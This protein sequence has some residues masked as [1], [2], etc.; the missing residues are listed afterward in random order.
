MIM[1]SLHIGPRELVKTVVLENERKEEELQTSLEQLDK[2]FSVLMIA[3][4]SALD[5]KLQHQQLVLVDFIRWIEHRMDWVGE[6]SNVIDLN[7][8]LK[9]LHPYFDFLDCGLIVDMSE[10]FL[11]DECFGDKDLVSQL[12][13]HKVKCKSLRSSSTVKQL[14]D[15]LKKI[16]FPHHTNP[17]NM[18][19]I[20]IALNNTWDEVNIKQ[21]YLLIGH[22]LPHKS[23][24][25]ILKH[26]EIHAGSVII[27]FAVHESN[28]ECLIAYAQ[29]KLQFMRL[30]GIF[31]LTINGK[32]ILKEDEN[33]NF[34]FKLALLQ[35]ANVGHDEAVQFLLKLGGNVNVK[36]NKGQTT[37]MIA[38]QKGHI[39]VIECLLKE[40]ADVNIQTNDGWTALMIASHYA[41]TQV[42][43]QL[44]R[45]HPDVN[46][47]NK[48]GTTS[49]ML[50][51]QNGHTQV[52][53][54]LLKEQAAVNLQNKEGTTSLMLASQNGH[55]QVVEQLLKEHA[56]V[57]LQSKEGVTALMLASKYGY[58]QVIEQLLKAHADVNLRNKEGVTALM[59][60]SKYGH[61]QVVE[62]LL[63][64]HANVNL[65]TNEGWT[66]LMTA[67]INGHTEVVE[68]LL[69]KHADIN[70]Q[71]N[72]GWT[73]LMAASINDHTTV[74]EVLLKEHADLNI[75]NNEGW[76]ALMLA[77]QN[78]HT[79][80]V[81]QLLKEHA[82]V[83]LQS[84]E[85][86][87]ALMLASKY[88]YTQVIEQLLKAHADVNL[89]NKE[90]VT[91]LMLASKYGHTQVVEQLLKEHA[92]VN[93]QTNE[94]W[95]ALMTASI[96]GHTEVVEQLLKKHAD[97]NIQ[98]NGGWTSLM[99][100]SINDH[101]T[102][103]E[104][105]LKEHAD[106]NIQ[107]NEGWTALMLA[108]RNDHTK[109]VEQLLKE[110]ADVN[111]QNKKGV[112]ALMLA[113]ENGHTQV[114]EAILKELVDID[115]KIRGGGYTALML[116]SIKG[117]VEVADCLLQSF[118]DPHI[119]A[120]NGLMAFSL[121][122]FNGNR[123]LVHMF[124]DKAEPTTDEIE[125]AVITSCY[126]GH[127]S[128]ITILS[129]KLA[130]L[131]VYQKELLDSCVKG[132]VDAVVWKTLD[133]S[134][135]DTPL[136]LGLTPLM[137]ASSCGHVDIVDVLIQ[138]GANVNKQ[139]SHF[140]FTPLFFAVQG[141]K[142]SLITETLLMY[143]A[144]PNIIA[145][146]NTP[147]DIAIDIKEEAI[148]EIL[149]NYGGQTRS[150]LLGKKQSEF[151]ELQSSLPT[152]C[153][154]VMTK[155]LLTIDDITMYEVSNY[156][157]KKEVKVKSLEKQSFT[158]LN[159][160]M[161]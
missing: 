89:R 93:L 71:S 13:E 161:T 76:T 90:G 122:T 107:N 81:E 32:R 38:S 80:V 140:G 129:N 23:K 128:L 121:A 8:L 39:Q 152:L 143:G 31:G 134:D 124:L 69:K 25:S 99:A 138:A 108:S 66:A 3:V 126:G 103:I 73:S 64:E 82:D 7:E 96:N 28:A 127:P 58:T 142:S 111:I 150:Q 41:H 59:L 79:K 144:H 87:T 153:Q 156:T 34:T 147:L 35:A 115:V 155:S 132:D 11:N 157:L 149:I 77:S 135:P 123:D 145:D 74:I 78:D 141:S 26:I 136:V 91:A 19:Q 55:T 159:K 18:P 70:I 60:A 10:Q 131:T 85:G 92:N 22:L 5:L 27:K 30:I 94:G 75:Q 52:V 65:Q 56:D 110:D 105:L 95:T 148:S 14:R 72:G 43:E 54:Q 130:H 1:S 116:A 17:S 125:K 44:L 102:V 51:S 20:Y 98:S 29:S 4:R 45:K 117:H 154:E 68:Q 119:I 151:S 12:K 139:E 50:A 146:N 21:L 48:K 114:V 67:S 100:A 33:M 118:A 46:L 36:D 133:S 2:N 120:Y 62:Q 109:V 15:D 97:I 83:N 61:T 101:T 158:S 106:L 9:K 42:I 113:S 6:L 104:V 40:H 57:N 137:V 86:V 53:E 37:L 49:L 112:T 24:Q 47:Q 63:K 160:P 16:Y 84:K 88:G